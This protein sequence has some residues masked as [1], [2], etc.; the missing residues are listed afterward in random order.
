MQISTQQLIDAVASMSKG[1]KPNEKT[2]EFILDFAHTYRVKNG[3]AYC[4]N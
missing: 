3:R 4:L 2:L 1:H